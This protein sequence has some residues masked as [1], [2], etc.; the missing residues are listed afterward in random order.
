M[1][2]KIR[3]ASVVLMAVAASGQAAAQARYQQLHA[4]TTHQGPNAGVAVDAAGNVYGTTA[5]GGK[6][7]E[8]L[9]FRLEPSGLLTVLHE[10]VGGS[11]DG[12]VPDSA[13][14][15]DAAGNLYGT[16]A[17]GGSASLGTVW[18]LTPPAS[19]HAGWT[20]TVLHSFVGGTADG[21]TPQARLL[22]GSDGT[23]YGTTAFGGATGM[24]TVFALAPDGAFALLHSFAG[25]TS[26]GAT[27]V[28][29]LLDDGASGFYG[30]TA[31]GGSGTSSGNGTVF[32]LVYSGGTWNETVLHFFAGAPADGA[33]SF[34]QL[35][36]DA[37]GT[38][39]G[40]T[41]QGGTKN[42]GTAFSL[43]PAGAETVIANFIGHHGRSPY[44]GVLFDA[45][46]RL[47]G[48]TYA[49]GTHNLG[50]I[51]LLA[52]SSAAPT[53]WAETVL[54]DFA[55]VPDGKNPYATLTPGTAGDFVGT[56]YRGGSADR[57]TVFSIKPP[58]AKP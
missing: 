21:A 37:N 3:A 29:G 58:K 56:T 36:A 45:N 31:A 18:K 35:V 41:S 47:L 55:G 40:T 2:Q 9:A 11:A 19:A 7:R 8:G 39:Y 1:S 4:F 50:T 20:E 12:A 30:T 34:S 25:G 48:T 43:T 46:G 42:G 27:P 57:G 28:A 53:G 16:T 32:H 44:A 24:G 10:F 15:Q 6:Y 5:G 52:P 38:L 49:G 51:F 33:A 23:L 13:P 54:W 22:L 14:I 26:D 17:Q